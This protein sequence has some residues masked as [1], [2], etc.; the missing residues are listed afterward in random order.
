[1]GQ[2]MRI[3]RFW[4][5]AASALTAL[6]LAACSPPPATPSTKTT[7]SGAVE[8]RVDPE[9]LA[10]YEAQMRRDQS[11]H[12]TLAIGADAPDFS[13]MGTDDKTHALADYRAS[14]ILAVV[15]ISNPCPASQLYEG[16]IRAI[17]ADYA[18]KGVAVVAIAPNGPQSVEPSALNYS[19]VDDS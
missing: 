6:F 9:R 1:M 15:F 4:A 16:R 5:L 2:R 3:L 19:D 18:A 13:L 8:E 12:P 10:A 17:V 14:P 11:E 7:Q